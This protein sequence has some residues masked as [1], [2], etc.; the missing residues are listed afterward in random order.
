MLFGL[1]AHFSKLQIK[2]LKIGLQKQCVL[3]PAITLMGIKPLINR[4]SLG[5][6]SEKLKI[7]IGWRL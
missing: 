5:L 3:H 1:P 6:L 4:K 2:I 7:I